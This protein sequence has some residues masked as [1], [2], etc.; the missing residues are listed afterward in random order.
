MPLLAIDSNCSLACNW[1]FCCLLTQPGPGLLLDVAYLQIFG[2]LNICKG[3]FLIVNT[4][5]FYSPLK[6]VVSQMRFWKYLWLV[7]YDV[8]TEVVRLILGK[9]WQGSLG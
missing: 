3:Q 4:T 2:Q 7:G 5:I 9:N 1:F 6:I 8:M